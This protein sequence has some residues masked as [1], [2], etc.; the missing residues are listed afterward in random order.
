MFPQIALFIDADN[1]S[2]KDLPYILK[3]TRRQGN[4]ILHAVYGD[5]DQP[6]LQ[7]WKDVASQ[8][9]NFKLRH[10]TNRQNSKNSTDMRLMMDAMEVLYRIPIDIFC[11]VTNDADYV[12]LCDKLY[13]SQKEVIGIGYSHASEAL[14]RSCGH[15]IFI[16]NGDTVIESPAQISPEQSHVPQLEP[17]KSLSPDEI[18]DLL[19]KAIAYAPTQNNWVTLSALGTAIRQV[20]SGF[21]YSNYGYDNLTRL[22]EDVPSL[23][24]IKV[25]DNTTSARLK[26]MTKLYVYRSQEL[27]GILL[28]AFKIV[29][30]ETGQWVNPSR[31]GITLR[32]VKE[33]FKPSHFGFSNLTQM[34]QSISQF[35]DLKTNSD[36]KV[37]TL[38]KLK[39][40][41]TTSTPNTRLEKLLIQAFEDIT[42]N[43]KQ[44]VKLSSF[45]T[46]LIQIEPNY[47]TK[48]GY[49]NL[50]KLLQSLPNIVELKKEGSVNFVRLK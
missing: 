34:L 36:D 49:S 2:Y 38:V 22:L 23:I 25:I 31:L 29:P 35:V 18:E 9:E 4:V 12:P 30:K 28:Q 46:A 21:E 26:D 27:E 45:G 1:I 39:T 40:Q 19:A 7:K 33:D 8:E 20:R 3:Q 11:I 48:Y 50:S 32:E 24:E 10:Q 17:I 6:H 5:W 43:K 47:K 13:E 41:K 37:V 16:K 44:W 15:F 14:I 42:N